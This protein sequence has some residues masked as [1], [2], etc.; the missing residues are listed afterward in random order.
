MLDARR[1]ALALFA[2]VLGAYAY[3]YQAGGWNQNSRFDLTRALVE[4]SA[5][6]IDRFR[7]N[8]GDLAQHDGHFYSDKAPGMSLLAVVPY[9]LARAIGVRDPDAAAYIVTVI[10]TG[11]PAALSVIALFFFSGALGATPRR[12][13]LI[14]AAYGLGTLIFPYGTMLYGH[15]VI[16]ACLVVAFT[17]L[18]RARLQG[19]VPG[20]WT[21]FGVGALLGWA[22]VIEY[23]AALVVVILMVYA[24]SFLPVRGLIALALGGVAPAL[25]LAGYHTVAFGGPL[26]LP[27]SFSTQQARHLGFFMG[28]G[29]PSPSVLVGITVSQFRGLFYGSPWL[30]LAAVGMIPLWRVARREVAVCVAAVVLFVWLNASLVDWDGGW[31]CGPRYLVPALPFLAIGAAGWPRGRLAGAALAVFAAVSAALMFAATTVNP[32]IPVWIDK[33][34]E[35]YLLRG[36]HAGY[37]RLAHRASIVSTRRK[38]ALDLRGTSGRSSGGMG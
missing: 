10:T 25:I 4:D 22:V 14:A 12:A 17:V 11:I 26:V 13:A 16:A 37:W 1:P 19:Q 35:D 24:A 8:T 31:A 27:Y 20:P 2:L 32:E 29:V 36:L 6:V 5:V 21:L 18:A 9:A 15:D 7:G 28:I 30:V 34:F 23:P 38:V 33:P 3:F